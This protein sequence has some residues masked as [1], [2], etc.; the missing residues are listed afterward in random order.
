MKF[1]NLF[2][3][4]PGKH[5]QFKEMQNSNKTNKQANNNNSKNCSSPE[6]GSTI[7]DENP[8]VM[9]DMKFLGNSKR[10]YR[11]NLHH[12][13]GRAGYSHLLISFHPCVS[14]FASLHNDET[15]LLLFLSH[16]S[17]TF[18]IVVATTA[19]R[20]WGWQA[21]ECLPPTYLTR[22][23]SGQTPGHPLLI[24]TEKH[25]GGWAMFLFLI[26]L[27]ICPVFDTK[28]ILLTEI[29]PRGKDIRR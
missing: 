12:Q 2:L 27:I 5:K 1:V 7:N 23:V 18:H 3:K 22:M 15:F 9:L 8:N 16:H 24:C 6:D 25:G 14:G 17:S 10:N 19:A 26:I 20:P 11:G 4:N 29:S 28:N 13:I 21:S